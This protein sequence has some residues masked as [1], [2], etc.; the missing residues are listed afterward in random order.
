VATRD[1]LLRA[2]TRVFVSRGPYGARVREIA[3]EAGLTVPALYYHFEGTDEL[4]DRVVQA[5]RA[6]FADM[7]EAALTSAGNARLRLLALARAYVEFGR[8]DPVRLRLLCLELFR[9]RDG[10]RPD[11]GVEEMNAWLCR[12]IEETLAL[13]MD[14][15]DVPPA[16]VAEA[17][18]FFMATL[19]GLLV[20]QAR[21]PETPLL[22]ERLAERAI[23]VF[24]DGLRGLA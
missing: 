23:S 17:R 24:V 14:A 6:R 3:R 5:G 21:S 13:G 16:D 2:A 20:E 18:R 1:A 15:G 22:D 10:S 12:R 8:E 7:A 11:H 19:N 9:P 4:Y